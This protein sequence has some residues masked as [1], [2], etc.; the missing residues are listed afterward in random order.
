MNLVVVAAV[1]VLSL[2]FGFTLSFLSLKAVLSLVKA[3]D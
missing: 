3:R 1:S 2:A